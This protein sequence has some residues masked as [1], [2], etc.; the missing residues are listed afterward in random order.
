M[1]DRV[2]YLTG[3]FI[4]FTQCH[5]LLISKFLLWLDRLSVWIRALYLN[6][7]WLVACFWLLKFKWAA[8]P[9]FFAFRS[10]VFNKRLAVRIFMTFQVGAIIQIELILID[11]FCFYTLTVSAHYL[12]WN[13]FFIVIAL[14]SWQLFEFMLYARAFILQ[15]ILGVFFYYFTQCI[16]ILS[17]GTTTNYKTTTRIGQVWN[18][19]SQSSLLATIWVIRFKFLNL[20]LSTRWIFSIYIEVLLL[21]LEIS[22]VFTPCSYNESTINKVFAS[23]KP[24]MWSWE[25]IYILCV[26]SWNL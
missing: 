1:E 18:V 17:L 8:D 16:T 6:I 9:T 2:F 20:S 21:I 24:F 22:C 15:L 5:K 3:H 10:L 7:Y 19:M 4:W 14:H 25:P 11:L 12:R 13:K 23:V 26:S